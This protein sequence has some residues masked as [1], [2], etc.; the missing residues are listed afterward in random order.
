MRVEDV[1]AAVGV[2]Y[3]L[4]YYHFDTRAGLLAATMDYNDELAPS[5]SSRIAPGTGYQR[6]ETALLADLA[7][8]KRVRTNN[9]VWN[10][11][12]A[13]AAFD[14]DLRERV[15]RTTRVWVSE[16]SKTIRDGQLDGSIDP[17]VEPDDEAELLTSLLSGLITRNLAG[18]T[19]RQRARAILNRAISS[20]LNPNFAAD[21][22]AATSTSA[23]GK[24]G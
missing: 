11:L 10:E 20:R 7:D 1:A 15:G 12:N 5:T 3:S 9:V 4:V 24:R 2:A 19:T 16:I 23:S 8:T 22:D 13:A 6:V 14:D 17:R 18:S 21:P